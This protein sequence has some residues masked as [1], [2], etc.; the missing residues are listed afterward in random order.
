LVTDVVGGGMDAVGHVGQ[1][2]AEKQN[3][4]NEYKK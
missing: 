4:P 3:V 2:D 1:M